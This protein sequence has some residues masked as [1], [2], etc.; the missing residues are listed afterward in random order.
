LD[1]YRDEGLFERVRDL[2]PYWEEAIHSLKGARHVID[3]RNIGLIGAI[4]LE[5]RP[6]APMKRT[7]DVFT[8]CYA[9]GVLVRQAGD[10]ICLS[11]PLIVEKSQIDR[12]VETLRTVLEQVD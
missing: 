5:P 10:I 8:G 11:P 9:E 3:L 12:I 7:Y 4:E 6:G 2:S 1:V